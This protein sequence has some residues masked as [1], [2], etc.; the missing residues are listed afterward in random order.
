[1]EQQDPDKLHCGTAS[2]QQTN[3][4]TSASGCSH[5]VASGRLQHVAEPMRVRP[6]PAE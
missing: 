2:R 6:T 1:M 4:F 3:S 5:A